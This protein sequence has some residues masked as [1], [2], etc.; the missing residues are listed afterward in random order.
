MKGTPPH[1]HHSYLFLRNNG[2]EETIECNKS[3]SVHL[4]MKYVFKKSPVNKL[5]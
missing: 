4:K 3:I 2:P 5:E 1:I